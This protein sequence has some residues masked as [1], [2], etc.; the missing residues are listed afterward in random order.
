M[1]S[2]SKGVV[3]LL[4]TPFL[5]QPENTSM[6]ASFWYVHNGNT[7]KDHLS[8][9]ANISGSL[10]RHLWQEKGEGSSSRP[11]HSVTPFKFY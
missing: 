8:V 6:C 7:N 3:G 9:Y 1:P 5:L 4:S 11:A 10:G 2:Q